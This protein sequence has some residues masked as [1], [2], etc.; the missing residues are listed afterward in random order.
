MVQSTTG[1]TR[2]QAG[3]LRDAFAGE[4]VTPADT[5][6]D[7][8]RRLWN[9][10]HERRPAVIVRPGT[11]R[12]SRRRSGSRATTTSSWR[13]APAATARPGTRRCDGGLVVDLSADAR[14]VGRSGDAH[15]AGERRHVAR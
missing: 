13:S 5:S 1:L 3:R 12:T 4:I 2:D 9:A 8:A 14:R 7:E 15:R 6:Y 11:A 10:V